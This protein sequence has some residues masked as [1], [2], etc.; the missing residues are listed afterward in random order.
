MASSIYVLDAVEGVN[1][2]AEWIV[3]R[4]P[5]WNLTLAL[6]TVGMVVVFLFGVCAWV[7]FHQKVRSCVADFGP[8]ETEALRVCSGGNSPTQNSRAKRVS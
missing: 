7:R 3:Y 1:K 2:G 4:P 6:W 5:L 8:R